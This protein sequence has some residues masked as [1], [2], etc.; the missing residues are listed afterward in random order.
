MTPRAPRRLLVTLRLGEMPEHIPSLVACRRYGV[1]PADTIDGGPIDRILRHH[2]GCIQSARLHNARIRHDQRPD[3]AG[4]RRYD[5]IEQLSGVARVLRISVTDD[6]GVP[7]LIDALAQLASVEAVRADSL[8]SSP[9]DT[10]A[11]PVQAYD[12]AAAWRSRELIRLPQALGFET[13]DPAII[14][15]LAD[16][17]VLDAS[18]EL[19]HGMRRGF[20]TVDLEP[21]MAGLLTLVGDNLGRDDDPSDE[22]GHGTG[23]AGILVAGGLTLPPGGAGLC[24]LTPVRVLGA[25]EQA[26][27][28]VGIGALSNI[29]AGM[30]RLIDLGAKV[31]NMSFGTA[32][33]ALTP[34]DP[35]PH[36]EVVRYALSRGVI[37]VAASGNSGKV[38]RY[39]PAAHDDVIAVGAVDD[40]LN[41]ARF[42]TRGEH[43]AL[44][45]PGQKIWTS[46]LAGY[47]Q[48][49]GTSFAAPFV[50]AVCA[51][52]ASY[53]QRRAL[54][55][56]P[57]LARD[58]LIRSARPFGVAGV[59]GCGAGV[60]DALAALQ[61]LDERL[62]E[63]LG[64]D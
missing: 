32:E 45:A 42:S 54:A 44:C 58:I 30:K 61:L 36:A 5:D 27:R 40:A 9:F 55:L 62:D 24:G 49:T 1:V 12:E 57:A 64:E 28:R 63:L 43:V 6:A 33:N 4:A 52:M 17:G 37:L 20:D 53:A 38:E 29:D 18:G 19:A 15:G 10:V 8:A 23:C 7:A 39:Y 35:R 21:G 2:G 14:V 51:L 3:V 25:A 11:T 48:A 50:S 59:E 60:L 46:G 41:P 31:I 13:G 47:Q 34:N 26:G 22:V 56:T 16:S